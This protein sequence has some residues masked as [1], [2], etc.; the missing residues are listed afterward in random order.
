MSLSYNFA[1]Y[2]QTKST[3]D[4]CTNTKRDTSGWINNY[5]MFGIKPYLAIGFNSYQ[6]KWHLGN[7]K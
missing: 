7:P 4:N 6:E 3:G 1:N 5:S 2:R